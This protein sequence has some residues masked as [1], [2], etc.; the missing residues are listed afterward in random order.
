MKTIFNA[1]H[2]LHDAAFELIGG[3]M[4]P[5]FECP[6]RAEIVLEKVTEAKL[7]P[8]IAPTA[9]GIAAAAKVHDA[10]FVAFLEKAWGLWSEEH[11]DSDALPMTWPAR[12]LRQIEP[13]SIDGKL[14]FYSFDAGCGLTKT[15]FQAIAAG[16]ETSLTGVDLI[17]AGETSAFALSRPP[18]HHATADQ[19]GGYCYLNNA[20]IAA[21]VLAEAGRR[22]AI[23]DVDYH[24][25][26]GTQAIFYERGDIYFASIH[27]HPTQEYPY[28]LGYADET[29]AGAGEGANLN[30]PL[31][32]GSA[33]DAYGAALDKACEGIVAFGA[34][35]VVVSLGLDTF[36]E[37]PISKFKL[38]SED[39]LRMGERIRK[40]GL[41]T[42]FVF[43]GGYAV[44]A[45]G[46]NTANVLIGFES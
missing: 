44:E 41:Q 36:E 31:Y 28:F 34:D 30:L 29:G 13:D 24:H 22:V 8:V 46:I 16:V 14:G 25:G 20:A 11:G 5:A 26:N 1:D 40:L 32:W 18:G 45:L 33:W 17:L 35:T 4:M 38:K 10:K 19:M 37:D 3:K 43:E 7:G 6:R 39:Y 42:L 21:Q 15:S 23:L 2:K 9:T 27:G 12:S